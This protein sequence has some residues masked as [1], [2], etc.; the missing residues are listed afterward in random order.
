MKW[1]C[2]IKNDAFYAEVHYTALHFDY[3]A[4]A[5]SDNMYESIDLALGKIEKQVSKQK[6]K[7]NKLHRGK[8][9]LIS[10]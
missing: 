1:S 2:Y 3:H 4:K 9:R 5:C 10:L 8:L 7:F 6:D